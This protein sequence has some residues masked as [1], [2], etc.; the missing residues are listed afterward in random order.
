METKIRV[1]LVE[2]DVVDQMA[3][4]RFVEQSGY[5]CE[6]R[7]AASVAEGKGLLSDGRFDAVV[8]DYSLGDG[9]ALDLSKEVTD[10]PFVVTTSIGDEL[11]AVNMMKAGAID[12]LAKDPEN[13]YLR[14]LP[15]ILE[16]AIKRKK[17]E[18]ELEQYRQGLEELLE[19]RTQELERVHAQLL[20]AQKM[21][22]IGRFAGSIAHDFNNLLT[23]IIGYANL[24]KTSLPP[25]D[26]SQDDIEQILKA[27]QKSTRLT[28]QLLTFARRQ[29]L[30]P[31]V[32]D[33]N[34]LV[35]DMSKMLR[36]LLPE[37]IE[38]V[39]LPGETPCHVE[40]DSGQIEQVII[41]L[42]VNAKNAMQDGGKLLIETDVFIMPEEATGSWRQS[43]IPPGEYVR[44]AVS[45][46][47]VGMTPEVQDRI[48]EPFFTTKPPGEGT[49]LGLSTVFGIIGQHNGY[50]HVY[51][52][53]GIGSTFKMYIPRSA[54]P[55]ETR[56]ELHVVKRRITGSET[57]LVVEDEPAVRR[58]VTRMLASLGYHVLQAGNGE[59]ALWTAQQNP[60]RIDLLL[61][62]VVMPQMGG[63]TLAE[64][65]RTAH[66]DIRVLFIS[67]YTD[68]TVLSE[69]IATRK[70]AFLAKPF[71]TDMLGA[72]VREVLDSGAVA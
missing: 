26:P 68:D 18:Q 52:E 12:Y 20:H 59:E 2:D 62:D 7:I 31:R 16:S 4:K 54:A 3:F 36:H 69:R 55:A 11:V 24:I 42:A 15:A 9:T 33:M 6:Y 38:L 63:R 48:F 46:T 61:S 13:N 22:S 64:E 45:D 37:N 70:A 27:G 51:S 44:V 66:P 25:D 50:I 32:C 40:V 34:E 23:T 5:Q 8:M 14:S 28:S 29:D 19:E 1:L 35:L 49:G 67:G 21:E 71:T 56:G 57:I 53:P 60:N 58:L 39:T 65:I 47:G 10:I 43:A 17:A 30:A 41:N 72:K